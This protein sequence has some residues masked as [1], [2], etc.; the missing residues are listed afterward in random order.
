[1]GRRRAGTSEVNSCTVLAVELRRE[2]GHWCSPPLPQDSTGAFTM[3]RVVSLY[4]AALT[5]LGACSESTAPYRLPEP[6]PSLDPAAIRIGF[7]LYRC[8]EWKQ[9]PPADPYVVGDVFFG[10]RTEQDPDDRPLPQYV[11]AIRA[12]GGYSLAS[13]NFPA[14]RA[15]LRASRIPS[16]YDR[17]PG[18]S[19]HM[20]PDERRYDWR[21]TVGYDQPISDA[22]RQRVTDLGGRVTQH[23][24]ALNMLVVELPNASFPAL[25]ASTNVL[26]VEA[27]GQVC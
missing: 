11:D 5:V 2:V 12:E 18:L 25:R 26:F 8:G 10:R 24:A 15:Y 20:V 1:M 19:V 6:D 7:V 27:A 16:L 13:F 22:D 17:W 4:L 3:S 23:F 14:V 21:A 9:T